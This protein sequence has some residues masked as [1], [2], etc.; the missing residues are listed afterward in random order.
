MPAGSSAGSG[1]GPLGP[2]L[3]RIHAGPDATHV[4]DGYIHLRANRE[5]TG[6]AEPVSVDPR[7]A[8]T[9]GAGEKDPRE[10]VRLRDTDPR[11]RRRELVFGLTDI[12]PALEQTGRQPG[13]H[14]GARELL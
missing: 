10:V 13:R 4:E 1:P 5:Q 6:V 14:D 2:G 3:G 12:R 11:C 9:G 8:D 7:P